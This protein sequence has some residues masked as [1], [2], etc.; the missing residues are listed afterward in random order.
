M[1]IEIRL[2]QDDELYF[3][4]RFFNET[5]KTNRSDKDFTWEFLNG[6]AGKALYV[7]AID[8]AV[9]DRLKIVGIQ[10]AI[11]LEMMCNDGTIILTAKSE[12]T[13]VDPAYRGQKLFERMYDL[14]FQAS[15]DR[16]IKYIWGF[17]PAVKAFERIGFEIPFQASQALLVKRPLEA[18][19]YLSSLNAKNKRLDRLKILLLCFASY[20]KGKAYLSF[21][22]H[23]DLI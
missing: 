10:C 14:L 20:L 16:G 11:P 21:S 6:P 13:L 12:D 15:R 19:K 5:Y 23:T 22:R 9:T 1:A 3:A 18:S 2:L 8:T 4:N 7:A 17:T